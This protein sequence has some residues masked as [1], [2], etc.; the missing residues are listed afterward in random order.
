[1]WPYYIF[2]F[3]WKVYNDLQFL[4]QF[5]SLQ[6]TIKIKKELIKEWLF[7]LWILNKQK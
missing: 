7:H 1:M 2:F 6:N 3:F 4:P 5:L